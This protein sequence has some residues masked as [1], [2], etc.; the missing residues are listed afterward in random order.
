LLFVASAILLAI[1]RI[2]YVWVWRRP[3]LFRAL[4]TRLAG[5][6]GGP[7]VALERLFYCFKAIQAAVFLAWC[8]SYGN[9]VLWRADRNLFAIVLGGGLIAVGQ[10]LIFGVFYRLGTVGV[11]YGNRF[12]Y[13]VEWCEQFPF[14]LLAHPQYV[15]ALLS[16]WGFFLAMRFPHSDWFFLPMLETVY[17]ALG[18][19]FEQ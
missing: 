11:F 19:Y 10:V 13:D 4:C 17:Y 8:Y 14:S 18:A 6:L 16:I 9:G 5:V 12:G 15:G 7:V 3:D 1:E 2:A